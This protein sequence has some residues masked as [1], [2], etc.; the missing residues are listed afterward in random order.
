[1]NAAKIFKMHKICMI[2]WKCYFNAFSWFN[3]KFDIVIQK[4]Q[5]VKSSKIDWWT[6]KSKKKKEKNGKV[7]IK[8][9]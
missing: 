5:N 9:N 3:W 4:T 1:M 8:C 2:D 7:I 6:E